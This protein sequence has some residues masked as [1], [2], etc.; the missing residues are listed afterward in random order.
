MKITVLTPTYN[1]AY[2]L[3]RL[4]NSLIRQTSNNFE[5]LVVDDGSSDGTKE[6]INKY[7]SENKINIRYIYQDNGGKHRAL[8]RGIKEIKNEITFIVDS[9]DYLKD[10][11]IE[12]IEFYDKKYGKKNNICGYSFLRCFPNGE[13]NGQKF[14]E[15]EYIS[16]YI[17]CRLNENVTGDKAEAYYTKYLK[18]V[19]F[20]EIQNEKFLFE[21]YVWIKLAEKYKMVHINEPIYIGNYLKDGLTKN[22]SKIK[23]SSP[24]GMM[25]RALVLCSKKI[26]IKTRI[27]GM[28]MYIAYGK[29]ANNSSK[30]L[31]KRCDYK[32]LYI[33]SYIFAYLFYKKITNKNN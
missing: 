33:F 26:N 17:N 24:I 10:N 3:E 13:I 29:I 22:I 2:I 21:D 23:Y 12:R 28:M 19:P 32:I 20:L 15:N 16:D 30:I 1:R 11:A 31:F 6:L 8:N 4:Y 18:E 27:K 25:E 9:D 14:K 7:I 5:W